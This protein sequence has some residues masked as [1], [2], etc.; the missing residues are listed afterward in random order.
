MVLAEPELKT[1]YLNEWIVPK[2]KIKV[3]LLSIHYPLAMKSYFERAFRRRDDVDLITTGPYTGTFIPW[4]GGMSLPEKYAKPPTIPLPFPPNIGRV[5]Y[6]F[7]KAQ[8]PK[9][10]TPDIIL[11][12]DAGINWSS[13]PQDGVVCTI[14]TDPHALNY[15]Y[16]RSISDKFFNMQLCYSES[17]DIY[18]PYAYDPTVHYYEKYEFSEPT[19]HLKIQSLIEKT[20]DTDAVLIG[21]PYENRVRWVDELRKHGVSVI[22]ENSP[23]FDEYRE[24]A[25][26]ARIGLNWSS[27]NDLNARFFETPAFGLAPVMNRVPDAGMFLDEEEDYIGFDNLNGAIEGVLY[28]KNNP[29]KAQEMA[30]NAFRHIEP[31]TYDKRVDDILR[32]CGFA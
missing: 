26:R 12:I 16:Q 1:A 20:K 32:E 11:S 17:K 2:N 13:K 6:D 14:A 25:N 30:N 22:F 31:H 4:M 21:M 5:S 8:L 10:W 9:D 18:L 7:V 15:D 24:L 27:M 29:D 23:V 19:E 28:L 3:L